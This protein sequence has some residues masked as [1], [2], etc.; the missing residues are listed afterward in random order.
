MA[1]LWLSGF[2][3]NSTDNSINDWNGAANAPAIVSTSVRSGTYAM[4]ANRGTT[5]QFATY[6]SYKLQ[7]SASSGNFY[8]RIYFRVDTLASATDVI[9][10]IGIGNGSTAGASIKLKIDGKLQLFNGASQVGTDSNV[11][12]LSTYYLIELRF[13]SGS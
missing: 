9:L 13:S 8:F 2:E 10:A 12:S 5:G 1:R 6:Y 11:L 3:L 4:N 7:S